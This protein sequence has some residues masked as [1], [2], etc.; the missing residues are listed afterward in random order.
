[1]ELQP[2]DLTQELNFFHAVLVISFLLISKTIIN[3]LIKKELLENYWKP[4]NY[5]F[6][7]H[8]KE[9]YF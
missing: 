6:Y 8:K 2:S 5:P 3:N 4:S 7:K 9:F 1:M